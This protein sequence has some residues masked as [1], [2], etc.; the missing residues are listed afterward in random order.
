[1]GVQLGVEFTSGTVWFRDVFSGNIRPAQNLAGWKWS[2]PIKVG[3][4]EILNE[5]MN[6]MIPQV[7]QDYLQYFTLQSSLVSRIFCDLQ[8]IDLLGTVPAVATTDPNIKDAYKTMFSR[9]Y[10][11]GLGTSKRMQL[12]IRTF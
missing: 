8:S 3:F 2:I 1:L 9:L 4:A 11:I 12:S 5:T 6:G 10:Q 7:V